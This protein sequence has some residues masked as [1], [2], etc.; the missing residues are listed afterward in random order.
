MNKLKIGYFADGPWSHLAFEKIITDSNLEVKFIVPRF[1]TEDETLYNYARKFD[2]DYFKLKNVNSQESLTKIGSY[3]CDLLVSMS[4]NQIFRKD[5]IELT[6]HKI[7][8]CH[9]GKLPFY[10]GRNILNWVLINDENEFGITVHYVDE[11]ID[12]GDIIL[13]RVFPITDE[14]NYKSLLELSY[15]ECASILYDALQLFVLNKVNRI[16]QN[17]IHPLGI[18]CGRRSIGDEFI[19]WNSSSREIFNFIRSI[20]APGPLAHTFLENELIK[21]NS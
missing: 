6:P 16:P 4:F 5:I 9:A 3:E 1:D 15:K 19:N 11:G 13:Q 8:N 17:I 2:I 12:T 7:I 18:Y 10:R 21:I 14:D 20:A